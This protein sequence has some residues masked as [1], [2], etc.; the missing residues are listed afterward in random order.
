MS[1]PSRAALLGKIHK[2]LRKHYKIMPD[3]GDHPVL[4][5]LLFGC[6]L[7]NAKHDLARQVFDT[8]RT[9][10]FDW[11]EVRVTTVKEL[12]EVMHA[13]PEP[14]EAASRFKGALQSVFESEYSFDLESL[15]KQ[16]IGQA[17]KRLHKFDGVTS[18]GVA[19]VTQMSLG[20]HAIPLDRGALG[21]LVVLGAASEAEGISGN[22]S[23]MERAIPKSKGHEFAALLHELGAEHVVHPYA[24]SYRELL[25]SIN[26]EAKDRLPKRSSK[27]AEPAPVESR[28][29]GKGAGKKKPAAAAPVATKGKQLAPSRKEAPAGKKAPAPQAKKKSAPEQKKSKAKVLAKRK[30]R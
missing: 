24:P 17:V 13:L 12:A 9:S 28:D 27:K 1:T 21:A 4:E 3:R 7:E 20:G 23:G 15:K 8:V 25:L 22:V 5:S 18:F 19:Y 10:F 29:A 30:P 16:N 6:L 26:P 2:V 14:A 11:N